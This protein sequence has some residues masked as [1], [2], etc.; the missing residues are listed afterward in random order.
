MRIFNLKTLIVLPL[1]AF[2]LS[3]VFA[4]TLFER[5]P[6]SVP[7]CQLEL[8]WSYKAIAEGRT[9]LKAEVIWNVVLFIPIGILV[10]FILSKK[11]RWLGIVVGLLLSAGIEV[12]Q[13]I[14][15]RGLFEFDDIIHNTLGI[16]VGMS[17]F[18][19]VNKVLQRITRR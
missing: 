11:L 5:I 15:Y 8:F 9:D 3:F 1:L 17:F 2:Y 6:A 4:I 14:F 18:L 19:L 12:G 7:R 16:V 10:M 13:L